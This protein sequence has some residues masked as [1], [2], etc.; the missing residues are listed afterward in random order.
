MRNV[1]QASFDEVLSCYVRENGQE[2]NR[3]DSFD[4]T[5]GLLKTANGEVSGS[6]TLASLSR[7]DILNIMLPKHEHPLGTVL[8]PETGL[9]VSAAAERIKA[10]THE[11]GKCWENICSHKDRNPSE[12]HIFLRFENGGLRHLD[13]LH[14]LLA[15]VNF[16]RKEE[17]PAYVA[18]AAQ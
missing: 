3:S 18:G 4:Y 15:W 2:N 8:I 6:W 14:R 16:K 10:L 12:M 9:T 7:E 1:R 11:T 13:G 17:L 5:V